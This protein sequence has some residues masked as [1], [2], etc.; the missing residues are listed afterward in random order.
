MADK[1][2][3]TDHPLDRVIQIGNGKGGVGKTSLSANIAHEAARTGKR[4]L[5]VDLDPQGNMAEDLGY[6]VGDWD[7]EGEQL[8]DALI[9]GRSLTP[10][11]TGRDNLDVICGGANLR[12]AERELIVR[13][14]TG[15]DGTVDPETNNGH[16][17]TALAGPLSQIAGDYDLVVLDSPPGF[18]GLLQAALGAARWLVVPAREDDSSL[19][20]LGRIG[21]DWNEAQ[22]RRHRVQFLAV[23]LFGTPTNASTKRAQAIEAL[24]EVVPPGV[25]VA[26]TVI[27][28]STS[29]A[30]SRYLG[31]T[32]SEMAAA[33]A[34]KP[35]WFEIR[36]KKKSTFA[37]LPLPETPAIKEIGEDDVMRIVTATGGN[38]AA[39]AEDYRQLTTE[40]LDT[41]AQRQS[42]GLPTPA[43]AGV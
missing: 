37:P 38:V 27:R 16:A 34:A 18:E 11:S 31:L 26:E 2:L 39:L 23:V 22:Q 24:Q 21:E 4:V 15:P 40:I 36:R 28:A 5:V 12:R 29:A 20:G 41:I 9:E 17:F 35:Q 3:V 10:H 13:S 19:K 32:A 7:D 43:T 25:V 42:D 30:S 14:A 1:L 6:G 8:A 33:V